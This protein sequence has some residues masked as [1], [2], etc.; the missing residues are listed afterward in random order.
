MLERAE[1]RNRPE[2]SERLPADRT[3]V[4]KADVEPVP[5]AGGHLR[6]RQSHSE[7][8]SADLANVVEQTAPATTEVQQSAIVG[9]PDLLGD[10]VVLAALSLL[11]RKRKVT[12]VL[13]AAEIG[14]LAEREP[15]Y[16]IGQRVAEVDV[17]AVGDCKGLPDE[18]PAHNCIRAFGPSRLALAGARMALE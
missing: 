16:A 15:D 3:G 13:C 8:G 6:G 7:P 14:Q 2:L 10:V 1:A 5:A 17:S 4:V 18:A 11:E 12:V 9:D